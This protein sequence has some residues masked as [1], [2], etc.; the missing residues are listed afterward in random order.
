MTQVAFWSSNWAEHH[1]GV[2]RTKVGQFGVTEGEYTVGIVH[3][4][5]GI[6]GQNFWKTNLDQLLPASI[7]HIKDNHPILTHIFTEDIGTVI[8]HGFSVSIAFVVVYV[9][10][11]TLYVTKERIEAIS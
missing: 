1:T 7:T 2:L 10:T 8:I 5:T 3:L 4:L 11:R 6:F 9:V